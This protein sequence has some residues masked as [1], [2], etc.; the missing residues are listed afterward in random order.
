MSKEEREAFLAGVHI[1]VLAVNGDGVPSVTPIWYTYEPGGDVV[2]STAADS[3]KTALLRATGQASL[4]VQT[5]TAP[6]I[7]V[8]VTGAVTIDDVTDPAW[9]RELAHRYL[10]PELGDM[11]IESTRDSEAS[12]VTV[13]LT[14]QRWHTTDYQKQFG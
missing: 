1:G 14:P 10:G 12:S 3:P 5:E 4:C 2:V 7:Y 11:Y 13:R 8:V 6:Y 9:R